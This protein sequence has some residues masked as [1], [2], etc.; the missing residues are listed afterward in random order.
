MMPT[1][2]AL[3]AALI[4]LA[5][6]LLAAAPARATSD[7]LLTAAD[8]IRAAVVARL[9]AGVEVSIDALDLSPDA[10]VFRE[11]RPDPSAALGKPIRFALLTRDGAMLHVTATLSVT[12]AHVI[13]RQPIARGAVVAAA[14]VT[15]V[16]DQLRGLPLR[17]LPSIADVVGARALRRMDAGVVM[18]AAFVALPR[19]VEPGD[20][21]VVSA[22]A[23]VVEVTASMVAIDGGR[24]GDVIRIRYPESRTFLRGRIVRPGFLE[25]IHGR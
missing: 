22:A 16:R 13:V 15:E 5:S 2:R 20:A 21:V 19:A 1:I 24:V 11:A 4:A 25:V 6:A 18:L 10:P 3:I 8:A 14:D 17:H 7:S 12:V 9:G 23:G